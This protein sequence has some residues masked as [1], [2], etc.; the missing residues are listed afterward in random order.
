MTIEIQGRRRAHAIKYAVALALLAPP[1]LLG[2]YTLMAGAR[3][4]PV[5]LAVAFALTDSEDYP[6]PGVPVRVAFAGQDWQGADAGQRFTTDTKG[7]ARFTATATID[8]RWQS[9]A[10]FIPALPHRADHL[11]IAV[12]FERVVPVGGKDTHFRWLLVS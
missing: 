10:S 7:E 11:L 1:I 9:T 6:L 12:E 8:K 4:Q 5:T 2:L 3:E